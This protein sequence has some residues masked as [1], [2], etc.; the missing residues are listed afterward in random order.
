MGF[1]TNNK[2]GI[3]LTRAKGRDLAESLAETWHYAKVT[4]VRDLGVDLTTRGIRQQPVAKQRLKDTMRKLSHMQKLS[5]FTVLQRELGARMIVIGKALWG[6]EL[7]P[8][9]FSDQHRRVVAIG[10]TS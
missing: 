7:S 2:T 9:A 1:C 8:L 6:C 3:W 10:G 5:H 4:H